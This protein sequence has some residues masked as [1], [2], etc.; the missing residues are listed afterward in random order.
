[1]KSVFI[2]V[3]FRGLDAETIGSNIVKMTRI[4]EAIFGEP[5]LG[6]CNY[7]DKDSDDAIAV[8]EDCKHESLL[9]LSAALRKMSECDY[10][11]GIQN[12]YQYKGCS[13][14]NAAAC[15]YFDH[16]NIYLVDTDYLVGLQTGWG[17]EPVHFDRPNPVDYTAFSEKPVPVSDDFMTVPEPVAFEVTRDYSDIEE[18]K[19]NEQ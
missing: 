3:P 9:Y 14:E 11:I 10:Y 13:V 19:R 16:K 15:G 1:M 18:G 4:A 6:I 8:P 17:D 2:S 12:D 5:L 7:F